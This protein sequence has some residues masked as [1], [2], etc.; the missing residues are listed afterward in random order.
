MFG[1]IKLKNTIGETYNVDLNDIE[2]TKHAL[3]MLGYYD[4]PTYGMNTYPD[5]PMFK[6]IKSFQKK[7]GLRVDGIMRPGGETERTINRRLAA[8]SPRRTN[9]A[10]IEDPAMCSCAAGDDNP[11]PT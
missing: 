6:G 4:I 5:M 10:A 7:T 2:P 3:N 8:L 1:P 11:W 9:L